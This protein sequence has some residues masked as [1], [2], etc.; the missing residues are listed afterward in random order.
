MLAA[1]CDLP[2]VI[3]DARHFRQIDACVAIQP[4]ARARGMSVSAVVECITPLCLRVVTPAE[5]VLCR[6]E[7]TS[8]VTTSTDLRGGATTKCQVTGLCA[9]ID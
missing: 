1:R 3:D 7:C 8:V 6:R 4:I 5:H 9:R 2:R